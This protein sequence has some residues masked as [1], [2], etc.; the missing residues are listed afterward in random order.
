MSQKILV[1]TTK[2]E[3]HYIVLDVIKN[4]WNIF[5]FSSEIITYIMHNIYK[6]DPLNHDLK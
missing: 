5:A 2:S 1:Q 4:V 6:G 3:I